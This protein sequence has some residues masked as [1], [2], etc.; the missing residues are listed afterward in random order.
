MVAK[1]DA[2]MQDAGRFTGKQRYMLFILTLVYACHLIDR[3]IVLVLLDPIKHE[4]GLSDTQLGLFSGF[5][6]AMGTVAAALPLGTLADRRSRKTILGICIAIWSTMTLL[7]GFAWSYGSLLALRFGVGAAEA[8][9]QPTALSMVADEVPARKRAKAVAIVHIGSPLGTLVGF[10]LGGWI[11]SHMGW[12]PALLLVGVP[13]LLLAVVVLVTLRE[14]RREHVTTDD[15]A[16]SIGD[17][18]G[19]IWRDKALLH[20]V[21]GAIILWLCTSSSSAWWAS[22]LTRSHGVPIATVGM[23]MAG[24]A[25]FGGIVGNFIAGTL[26]ERVAQGRQDRLALIAVTGALIYFPLSIVTLMADSLTVVVICLFLQMSSYFLVFTPA[27]S[28][29]MGLAGPGIRGR[30]AALMSMGATAIGY[31]LGSQLTGVLSDALRPTAGDESL[32]YALLI[33]MVTMLW[34]AAHFGAVYAKLRKRPVATVD[35]THA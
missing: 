16:I 22:F 14:P 25:G 5:I 23:I 10:V 19:M 2:G 34:A 31:G 9:L 29:A 15:N 28:L 32:R 35:V 6:F 24:T 13:G 4:Y 17:F 1:G 27:Y 8:G 20:V 18:F 11:A 12:R 26:S 3:T 7:C 21:A 30:T 33:M